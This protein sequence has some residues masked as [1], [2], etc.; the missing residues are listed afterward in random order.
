M[1]YV[2][3]EKTMEDAILIAEAMSRNSN[4]SEF[5]ICFPNSDMCH[6]FMGE[7]MK[8][9]SKNKDN[10]RSDLRINIHIKKKKNAQQPRDY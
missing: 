3:S 4:N 1:F 5:D 2:D 10:A 8:M 9:L 6:L 7:S